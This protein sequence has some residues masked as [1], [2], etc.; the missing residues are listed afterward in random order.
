MLYYYKVK[1]KPKYKTW[2]SAFM[3]AVATWV[4]LSPG[5]VSNVLARI[6]RPAI[7]SFAILR[8]APTAIVR[9]WG[10]TVMVTALHLPPARAL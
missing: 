4:Y 2:I 8:P 6:D 7:P 1:R 3:L 9:P 5:Y 10:W